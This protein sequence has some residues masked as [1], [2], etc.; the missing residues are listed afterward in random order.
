MSRRT[1]RLLVV[2]LACAVLAAACAREPASPTPT[3]VPT[4]TSVPTEAP[5][6]LEGRIVKI[7]HWGDL[8]PNPD[9]ADYADYVAL[10]DEVESK[11]N[12]TFE[13]ITTNDWHAYNTFILTTALS[14][15]LIADVF[16]AGDQVFPKWVSTDLVLP[17]NDIFDLEHPCWN[18]KASESFKLDDQY[19]GLTN[20]PDALGHVVLF[21]KR[22]ISEFNIPDLYALQESGE[23]TWD[24]LVEYAKLC[25]KDRDGDSKIDV[26][27]FGTYGSTG[28]NPEPFIYSNGSTPCY[29]DEQGKLVFNLDDPAAIEAIDFCHKLVEEYKVV[30]TAEPTWGIWEG[31][32]KKGKIA[33]FSA[34]SWNLF[35]YREA[36]ANDQFGMLLMPRGPKA[37][38]YV[39]AQSYPSG[40]FM[41]KMVEE[42]KKVAA[43][44]SD[45]FMP[46]EWQANSDHTKLWENFVFDEESLDTVRMIKGR[47]VSLMGGSAMWFRDNVLW[48]DWGI[49][50][51]IPTQT[52]IEEI[53]QP[54]IQS[55]E[56][57]WSGKL[58]LPTPVPEE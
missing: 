39:N 58:E 6:D 10:I 40:V 55:F 51:K 25:T 7:A 28:A 41:Q 1:L 18:L 23:W 48:Y 8:N 38:D 36:L 56:D 16:W 27:G 31:L 4:P 45:L 3:E 53:R 26:W 22:I 2:V 14:G 32:W 9:S 57:L 44:L 17:L 50:R 12:C 29:F 24:K 47:T 5:I 15:E 37:D 43:A 11:Y 35:P 54:S 34:A 21:N 30:Y 20:W 42:P 46:Q 52:F 49:N 33:F 13:F 19:Y